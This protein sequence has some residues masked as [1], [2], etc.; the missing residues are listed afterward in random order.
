MGDKDRERREN[1]R[2]RKGEKRK[3]KYRGKE[4]KRKWAIR[5]WRE[6]KMG[7]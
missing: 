6:G 3:Q 7:E 1:G 2:I 5:T 4:K